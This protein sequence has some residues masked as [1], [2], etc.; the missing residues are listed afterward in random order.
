[1]NKSVVRMNDTPDSSVPR[2]TTMLSMA[3]PTVPRIPKAPV[4]M[5]SHRTPAS[6][7]PCEKIGAMNSTASDKKKYPSVSTDGAAEWIIEYEQCK[8][9]GLST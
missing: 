7:L 8:A 6:V 2:S 1:M 3:N 9:A 5:N 4:A